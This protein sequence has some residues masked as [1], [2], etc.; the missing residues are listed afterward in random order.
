ML[1]YPSEGGDVLQSLPQKFA[2]YAHLFQRKCRYTGGRN[3]I[4]PKGDEMSWSALRYQRE[5]HRSRTT[6]ARFFR[7]G[8]RL[9]RKV[10]ISEHHVIAQVL[11][12]DAL[13]KVFGSDSFTH[14]LRV[15]K[16]VER[17]KRSGMV[18]AHGRR[19]GRNRHHMIPRSRH[20][21]SAPQ[22]L[23]LLRVARH[24]ALHQIFG[25]KTWGEIIWIL[26]VAQHVD[27][28][29]PRRVAEA[30]G[31]DCPLSRAARKQCRPDEANEE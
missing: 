28:D 23:L 21:S 17:A 13:E 29:L 27:E 10:S 6:H 11:R 12:T 5:V 4:S 20:G 14:V 2:S 7:L 1:R 26:E 15:A 25:V 16:R 3:L 31:D 24:D 9:R 30:R 8:K 19:K 18:T 22:N